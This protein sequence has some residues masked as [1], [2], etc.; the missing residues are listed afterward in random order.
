MLGLPGV[1]YAPLSTAGHWLGSLEVGPVST[2][3]ANS[4]A[5]AA[6]AASI[7]LIVPTPITR[8]ASPRS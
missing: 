8:A 3:G 1:V 4:N 2:V 6:V 5:V 7:R